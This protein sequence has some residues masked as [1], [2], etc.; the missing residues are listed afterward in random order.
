MKKKDIILIVGVILIVVLAFFVTGGTN[1]QPVVELPL[2]LSGDEVGSI[3]IDY[4]TY[5][6]KVENGENFIIVIERTGCSFCEMY[7]P[8]LDNVTNELSIP[9][10]YIDT[11]DL[12][13]DEYYDLNDSNSYLKRNQWGTPTTLL[14][15]GNVVVDSISG[16][17]EKDAFVSEIIDGNIIL[18]Q[19]ENSEEE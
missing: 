1:A 14:M 13:E 2:A 8:V 5:K 17:V 11:A 9:V 19:E 12:T 15:S 18:D 4:S 16:Y 10:Y 3:K 7:M 6:S